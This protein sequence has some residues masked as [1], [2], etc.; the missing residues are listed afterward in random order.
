MYNNELLTAA[1]FLSYIF[2]KQTEIAENY[3][4][5]LLS[6][7]TLFNSINHDNDNVL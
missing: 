6:F 3:T 2:H 7:I 5:F 1:T 4:S